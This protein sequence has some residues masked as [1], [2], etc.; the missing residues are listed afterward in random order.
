MQDA[1][2]PYGYALGWFI[3]EYRGRKVLTHLGGGD[4]V[5]ALVSWMPEEQIGVAVLAN[6]EGTLGRIAIRNA[7]FDDALGVRDKDWKAAFA[8]LLSLYRASLNDEA[9]AFEKEAA[10]G[11]GLSFPLDAY[12]GVYDGGAFGRIVVERDGAGLVA[13]IGGVRRHAL[14]PWATDAFK[15]E[16]ENPS[17]S[18]PALSLFRFQTDGVDRP[19][20]LTFEAAGQSAVYRRLEE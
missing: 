6:A 2:A 12:E 17:F 16:L 5:A 19:A 11:A 18:W 15:I 13:V 1:D 3:G 20:S 10:S 7:I 4:G 14:L 8:K 9:A